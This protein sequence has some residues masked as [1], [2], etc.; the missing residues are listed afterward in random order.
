MIPLAVIREDAQQWL[1]EDIPF[2]DNS[3]EMLQHVQKTAKIRAKQGGV[4]SGVQVAIQVFFLCNVTATARVND[5][6]VVQRGTVLL[7]LE[8][9]LKNI[10]MAERTALN[11]FSHMSGISTEVHKLR[12]IVGDATLRIAATR[13]TL[14]GLRK[15]QK[16]AVYVAGGDT[17][18]MSLADM[19]MLKENHLQGFPS[20]T[21]AL[22]YAQQSLSFAQKI[23]IEVKSDKEAIE[24]VQT[25]I[26]QIIML[27][28]F[29]PEMIRD[30]LPKLRS[31][32]NSI[33]FE[34]SGNITENNIAE[35]VSS[36]V[37]I[38]SL[39]ALTHSSKVFDM[40][41]LVDEN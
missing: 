40:S 18:R 10:L 3:A 6:D 26:P 14:P 21:A 4:I 5:G 13:K 34:A 30:L 28:N 29:T 11:I 39:G 27:D 2:W 24:A 15:Y 32:N 22:E 20:I 19:V 16:W 23:E 9:N 37:D 33:L 8:G 36:G 41:L 7:E 38:V 1:R 31:I 17:H 12:S 25:G 35:Y